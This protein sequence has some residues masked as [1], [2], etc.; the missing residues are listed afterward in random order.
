VLVPGAKAPG[1]AAGGVHPADHDVLAADV[2]DQVQRTVD[3]DPPEVR[4]LAL[5]EQ[6][7]AGLDVHLGAGRDEVGE[8]V[9]GHAVEDAQA[10][11]VVDSHQI[12][13]R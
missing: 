8:L 6:L 2:A 11:Q 4:V 7:D 12:V 13:A 1:P 10:A 3:E 5:A 9:V